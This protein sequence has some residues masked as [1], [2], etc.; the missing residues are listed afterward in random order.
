MKKLKNIDT[1][2]KLLETEHGKIGTAK[3]TKYDENSQMFIIS[4]M[5]KEARKEEQRKQEELD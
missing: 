5:L 1:F 4:E 2:E 3:R